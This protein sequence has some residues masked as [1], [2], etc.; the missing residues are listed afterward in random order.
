[1]GSK[2]A[3]CSHGKRKHYCKDCDGAG[4]CE[5]K[6]YRD[7]CKECHGSQICSHNLRKQKCFKCCNLLD[8]ARRL[9]YKAKERARNKRVPASITVEDIWYLLSG[10][11]GFCPVLGIPFVFNQGTIS[12]GTPTL[13]RY[14]PEK[15]YAKGNV[16]VISF[17]ANSI[18]RNATPEQIQR[19]AD[20]AKEVTACQSRN[21]T[22]APAR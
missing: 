9:L 20:Y 12:D 4:I 16:A 22:T 18:K 8:L 1:M 13:D 2:G 14:K 17:L 6:K 19:V 21:S 5:H 11:E 15:G 10:T 3:K 7:A